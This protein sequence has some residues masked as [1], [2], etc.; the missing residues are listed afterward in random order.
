MDNIKG[1]I[2]L[3][4]LLRDRCTELP[5]AGPTVPSSAAPLY[6]WLQVTPDEAPAG[7]PAAA[8]PPTD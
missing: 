5:A 1:A 8:E 2:M 4:D 6:H 3:R 7:G